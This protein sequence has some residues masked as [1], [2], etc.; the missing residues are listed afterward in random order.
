M[1]RFAV[2]L[3][4]CLAA[5][6]A[7]KDLK[8]SYISKYSGIAVNEMKRSGVP[9]SITLAQGILESASGTSELSVKGN[10]HF[11]VKCHRNWKGKGMYYKAEKGDEC[12]RVYNSAEESFR[13]HSDFL[14]YQDR[15]KPLFNLDPSD[16]KGW[17]E[18]L[19]KAGYATD[20]AYP[21]KLIKIIEDYELYRFDRNIAV[22]VEAPLEIEKPVEVKTSAAGELVNIPLDRTVYRVNGV[23]FVYAME[24]ETCESLARSFNLFKKELLKFNDMESARELVGGERI[25]IAAK[26]K[27][28]ARGL[29]KYVVG[30]DESVSMW[31]LSQRFGI[32]LSSLCSMNGKNPDD[33]PG[34]EDVI[35]L[36]K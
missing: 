33:I 5:L 32:K 19:R 34:E 10:N 9:A 11:G 23:P 26:K 16:Y 2:I 27:Q 22:E 31:E 20:P 18:G 14:R 24:G 30:P 28:A 4:I 21:S 7:A 35:I 13:D 15:Y 8:T 6:S 29:D 36:R 12:F 25:Y 1:K 17:A 3:I